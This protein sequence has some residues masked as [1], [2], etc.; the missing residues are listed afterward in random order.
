MRKTD[1]DAQLAALEQIARELD[2][3]DLERQ[4]LE[5]KWPPTT[6]EGLLA[7][8]RT[9]AEREL[10]A[11]KKGERALTHVNDERRR[12]REAQEDQHRSAIQV[13]LQAGKSYQ[14]IA[15]Q[16]RWSKTKVANAVK[17]WG[18]ARRRNRSGQ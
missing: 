12:Q 16:L 5:R 1:A 6:G 2:R 13:R 11:R 10:E 9:P 17:R 3:F 4:L 7:Y 14:Q 15:S 8:L 18:I